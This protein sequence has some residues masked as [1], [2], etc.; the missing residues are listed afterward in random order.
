MGMRCYRGLIPIA[1]QPPGG[2]RCGWGPCEAGG[3]VLAT[4]PRVTD[5]LGST[6]HPGC[7]AAMERAYEAT[8]V[9]ATVAN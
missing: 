2:V 3:W 7:H 9:V 5:D 4:A 8:S 1:K 6:F